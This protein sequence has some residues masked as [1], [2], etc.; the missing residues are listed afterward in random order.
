MSVDDAERVGEFYIRVTEADNEFHRQ[1][2]DYGCAVCG[3]LYRRYSR[4]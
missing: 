3:E 1:M 2:I 4:A